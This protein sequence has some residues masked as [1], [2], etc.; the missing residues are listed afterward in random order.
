M[1]EESKL[2]TPTKKADSQEELVAL[3]Q[4]DTAIIV[5][6]INRY[7]EFCAPGVD[8]AFAKFSCPW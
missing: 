6:E 2:D 1:D 4:V 8:R 7:N 3:I 5:N